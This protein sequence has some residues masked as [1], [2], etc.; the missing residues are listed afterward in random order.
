MTPG[1]KGVLWGFFQNV[2]ANAQ[3]RALELGRVDFSFADGN[4]ESMRISSTDGDGE[5]QKDQKKP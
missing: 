3:S 5:D 4:L 1:Q 2:L